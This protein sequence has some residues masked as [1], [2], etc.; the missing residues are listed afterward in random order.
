MSKTLEKGMLDEKV[1]QGEIL[2]QTNS[3]VNKP[4][5]MFERDHDSE[6]K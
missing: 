3:D 1:L 4:A 5:S 6:K 2:E